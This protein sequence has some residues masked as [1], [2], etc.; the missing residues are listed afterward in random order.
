MK[1]L[2]QVGACL[3]KSPKLTIHP[4]CD[5][6]TCQFFSFLLFSESELFPNLRRFS[7]NSNSPMFEKLPSLE[8]TIFFYLSLFTMTSTMLILAVYMQDACHIYITQ[9]YPIRSK[10]RKTNR[11]T[12]FPRFASAT[13]DNFEF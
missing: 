4:L 11:D 13:C 10:K 5:F 8:F 1:D 12:I 9:F 2:L 6:P 3:K 7:P